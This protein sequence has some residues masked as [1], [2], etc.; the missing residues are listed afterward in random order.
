M[1]GYT[2]Y[3]LMNPFPGP[4]GIGTTASAYQLD[5]LG[6]STYAGIRAIS[7]AAGKDAIDALVNT[8]GGASAINAS[9]ASTGSPALVAASTGY[10]GALFY[11]ITDLGSDLANASVIGMVAQSVYSN[12]GYFQQ[13]AVS[14]SGSTLGRDNAYPGLY[15]TRVTASLNGHDFTQPL[16]RVD[17]T[18]AATGI[19]IECM[20]QT[21]VKFQVT[22]DQVLALAANDAT[23]PGFSFVTDPNTGM[24]NKAADVLGFAQNGTQRQQMGA[25]YIGIVDD[26]GSFQAGVS[27]DTQLTRLS[28]LAWGIDVPSSLPTLA[29]N[30]SISFYLDEAGNNLKVRVKYSTGTLKTGTLALV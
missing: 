3:N 6:D 15:V 11:N 26:A 22:K 29:K 14:G 19:L 24:Y 4:V 23:K 5:V 21:A 13:G 9:S 1:G 2:R 17:D 12:A 25:G 16:L 30:N 10:Y 7:N 18:T 28:A 8:A 27:L 20:K